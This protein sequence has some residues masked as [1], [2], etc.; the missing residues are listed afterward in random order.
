MSILKPA[1]LT[2]T[3]LSLV[4]APVFAAID[5]D[6]P[7]K[8]HALEQAADAVHTHLHDFYTSSYGAHGLETEATLIHDD[9]H[10][11]ADGTVPESQIAAD[12]ANVDAAWKNF[13]QTIH[14]AQI[15][16]SGDDQLDSLYN[17]AKQAHKDLRFALRNVQS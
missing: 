1:L 14:Q 8:S 4:A 3:C 6:A 13:K 15:L 12:W 5:S 2:L 16:N 11:W 9:L 10:D 17:D 7:S